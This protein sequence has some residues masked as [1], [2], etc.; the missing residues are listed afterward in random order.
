[1]CAWQAD[2]ELGELLRQ[3]VDCDRAAMLLGDDVP[4][5][6]QAEPGAFAGRLCCHERLEQ[7][8][9]DLGHDADAVVAHPHL[10]RVAEIA[11][12][13]LQRRPKIRPGAVALPLGGR[14]EAIT[15]TG[16]ETP[17]LSQFFYPINARAHARESAAA[18]HMIS[19]AFLTTWGQS[20]ASGCRT[21]KHWQLGARKPY[22]AR[23]FG[24]A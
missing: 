24:T 14:I 2:R 1:M 16:S 9:P 11:R 6:G 10:D 20:G 21:I 18:S 12:R 19:L 13:H 7:F 8:V 5:D 22:G 15:Q 3:A 23:L 4:G 17:G